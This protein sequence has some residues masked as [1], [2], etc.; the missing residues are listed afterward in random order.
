MS[1]VGQHLST[2][3][4]SIM[5]EKMQKNPVK[6]SASNRMKRNFS[7]SKSSY[8]TDV[9]QSWEIHSYTMSHHHQYIVNVLVNNPSIKKP[10]E[11]K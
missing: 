7:I 2:P 1:I 10:N 8:S 6:K 9:Q 5:F 11:L 4:T 3:G